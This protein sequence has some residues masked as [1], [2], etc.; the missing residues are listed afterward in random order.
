MPGRDA[1]DL[2]YFLH[3]PKTSGTSLQKALEQA[4]GRECVTPTQIWDHLVSG[5]HLITDRT[6][7]IVGHFGGLLPLWLNRWPR[8]ITML[9]DPIERALSHINHIQ[10][11][12]GHP[13]HAHS[14]GLNVLE[15]CRHPVLIKTVSDFQ[16]RYLAVIS[17]AAALV[18]GFHTRYDLPP[19]ARSAIQFEEAL[20]SLENEIGLYDSANEA[21]SRIDAV[22]I[23][24]AHTA[25]LQLFGKLFDWKQSDVHESR[26]N[27]RNPGQHTV[28]TLTDAELTEL[29][30]LNAV[31]MRIYR[32]ACVKFRERCRGRGIELEKA[33]LDRVASYTS[34]KLRLYAA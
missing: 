33:F 11:S 9:R 7:V 15:Y 17:F 14:V 12:T 29:E 30:R 6:R 28:E 22:G 21:I 27:T 25:S 10:R 20:Y 8:I 23:C 5:K 13:L 32:V 2:L 24:E 19:G 18:P 16:A 1:T 26:L 31:D 4:Y 3:I 34:P